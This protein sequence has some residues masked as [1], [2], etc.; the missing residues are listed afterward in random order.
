MIMCTSALEGK[1]L[2]AR[3]WT[4]SQMIR[5]SDENWPS[6]RPNRAHEG[7]VTSSAP[8]RFEMRTVELTAC[9]TYVEF[10]ATHGSGGSKPGPSLR[11]WPATFWVTVIGGP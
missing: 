10:A 3:A 9:T 2:A 5:T 7:T 4:A 8:E 1:T 6:T 11:V